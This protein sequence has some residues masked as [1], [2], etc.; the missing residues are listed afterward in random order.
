MDTFHEEL[1]KSIPKKI[2][3]ERSTQIQTEVT[4]TAAA[5]AG[6]EPSEK[7]V[8]VSSK[9]D[10]NINGTSISPTDQDSCQAADDVTAVATISPS[11]MSEPESSK[12]QKRMP[13]KRVDDLSIEEIN[14]CGIEQW[15][16]YIQKNSSIISH[17]FTGQLCSKVI[18]K[19]CNF[20]SV[21]FEV[22]N[23]LSLPLPKYY[24]PNMGSAT[25]SAK[26]TEIGNSSKPI[27]V[28]VSVIRKMPRYSHI[29]MLR[30]YYRSKFFDEKYFN[31]ITR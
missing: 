29:F 18:C 23:T 24:N 1:K 21:K 6:G 31:E 20:T 5:V 22:F 2:I 7:V 3:K 25:P 10:I 8:H 26:L 9:T 27:R 14:K 19:Y 30:K 17:V 11:V 16:L 13:P 4:A 15:E 28:V 12:K